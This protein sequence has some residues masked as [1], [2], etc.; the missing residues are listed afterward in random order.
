[1]YVPKN[2]K[3]KGF[4]AQ[5]IRAVRIMQI[6]MQIKMDKKVGNYAKKYVNK[7]TNQFII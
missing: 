4:W 7:I 3:I 2:F 6:K 1:M 5:I